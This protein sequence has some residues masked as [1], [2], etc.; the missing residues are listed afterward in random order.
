MLNRSLKQKEVRQVISENRLHVCAIL[1]SHVD[2]SK[3]VNVLKLCL[4]RGIGSQ[5]VTY[6]KKGRG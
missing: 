2:L 4:S 1:E 3:L 6:V 5:M